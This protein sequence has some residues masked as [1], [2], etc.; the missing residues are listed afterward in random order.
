M[1]KK[2]GPSHIFRKQRFWAEDG[3]ICLENQDSGEFKAISRAEAA[4]RAIALNAELQYIDFP[5]ERRELS[6]C[7]IAL[8][9]AVKEAKRQGDPTDPEVVKDR[10]KSLRKAAMVTGAVKSDGGIIL[11]SQRFTN[12]TI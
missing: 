5:D 1:I 3:V 10:I 7:V 6:N 4:A 8:C 2:V 11:G 12:L 9:A